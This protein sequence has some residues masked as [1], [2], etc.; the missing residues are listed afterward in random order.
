MVPNLFGTRDWLRG[1]QF[2]RGL[3]GSGGGLGRIQAHHTYC[4]LYVCYS[5]S[6]TSGHQALDSEVGAPDVNDC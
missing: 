1:R 2:F 5:I 4:A 6:S 3:A